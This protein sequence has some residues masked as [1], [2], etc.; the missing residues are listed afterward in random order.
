MQRISLLT[1]AAFAVIGTNVN[2]Q[3]I[4]PGNLVVSRTVY[5][6]NASTVSVGQTLPGGGKAV[7]DGSFPNVFKNEGPDPA[8]GVTA[9]IFLDQLTTSGARVGTIACFDSRHIA[10]V[11]KARL[12]S[13]DEV[14]LAQ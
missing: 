7:A 10:L 9:P 4:A 13:G 11:S 2:A 12:R 5:A 6:G 3:A 8:F 14:A 1:L